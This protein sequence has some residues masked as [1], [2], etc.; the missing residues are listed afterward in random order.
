MRHLWFLAA[1]CWATANA[2]TDGSVN[3][4][5]SVAETIFSDDYQTLTPLAIEITGPLKALTR[6]KAPE[7]QARPGTLTMTASGAHF[8]IGLKP[9]GKSRRKRSN[10][11]FPPLW[12]EFNKKDIKGTLFAGHHRRKLVTQCVALSAS[13]RDPSKI[14]LEMLAYRSLNLLTEH[15]LRVQ[16][17]LITWRDSAAPE[18]TYQH[19]G[20]ILEHKKELAQRAGLTIRKVDKVRRAT[21]DPAHANL[22]AL[23][24]LMIGNPDFS[25]SS[26]PAKGDCCHNSI[27][28]QDAAGAFHPVIYDFDNTGLV[29]PRYATTPDN[30]NL[31]SVRQRLYR[32]YCRHNEQIASGIAQLLAQRSAIESL[33]SAHPGVSKAEKKRVAKFLNA[34]F[35]RYT[36]ARD[37]QRRL[38]RQCLG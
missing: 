36:S 16:P 1:L 31:G 19:A 8:S 35:T 38:G 26:G 7:P 24:N 30:L 3:D 25:L 15:S 28:M 12:L 14:W 22:G 11:R 37:Q 23:F 2:A 4:Q 34:F 9:R 13:N 5:A 10:C 27:P 29:N 32:G 6:D 17:V 21:L 18:K 20:F 33:F